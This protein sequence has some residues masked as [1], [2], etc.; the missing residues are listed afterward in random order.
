M[1]GNPN[2]FTPRAPIFGGRGSLFTPGYTPK[3]RLIRVTEGRILR[4]TE[5]GKKRVAEK[6]TVLTI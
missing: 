4:V 2:L 5:D 1:A 6:N 3:D